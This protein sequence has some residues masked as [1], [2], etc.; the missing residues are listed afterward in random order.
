V[1]R[2]VFGLLVRRFFRASAGR[3]DDAPTLVDTDEGNY[4]VGE[5]WNYKTRPGEEGSLLTVLKV[6][7][8]PKLGVI[9]HISVDGLRIASPHAPNGVYETIEHMPF[10]EAS[11]AESITTCAATGASVLAE[12]EGYEEWRRGFDAG[13]AGIFTIP[14]ADAVSFMAE[15]LTQ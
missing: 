12:D 8:S 1:G 4:H 13:E 6:E 14:V 15:V 5:R 9:V 3:Q 7:S 11:I 10:A 2:V